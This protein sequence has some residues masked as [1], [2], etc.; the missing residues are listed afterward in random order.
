MNPLPIN[1]AQLVLK[2]SLCMQG[3]NLLIACPEGLQDG[4]L[5]SGFAQLCRDPKGLLRN[6]GHLLFVAT[7]MGKEET[8]MENKRFSSVLDE[9]LKLPG[10]C[11]KDFSIL[12]QPGTI[13]FTA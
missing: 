12:W 8:K 3:V 10:N 13:S 7:R 5:G 1:P 11:R 6:S 2:G 4:I 9:A